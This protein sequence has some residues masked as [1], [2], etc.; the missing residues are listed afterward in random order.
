MKYSIELTQKLIDLYT[1]G[2][3]TSEIAVTLNRSERS[4]I[5]KLSELRVYETA[6]PKAKRET[7]QEICE[8]I[9]IKLGQD[10]ENLNKL[11]IRELKL[12]RDRL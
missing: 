4:V 5:A 6:A 7:K 10:L 1:Q 2:V 11:T 3:S 8:A 9:C 12:L